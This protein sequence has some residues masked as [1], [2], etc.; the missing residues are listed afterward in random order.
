MPEEE[1]WMFNTNLRLTIFLSLLF[2][3]FSVPGLWAQTRP[4]A[5]VGG[6]LINGTGRAR[7][8]GLGDRRA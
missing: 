5:I 3:L 6:T 1:G 7:D 4:I 2:C 8:Y